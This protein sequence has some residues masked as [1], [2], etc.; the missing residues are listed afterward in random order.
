MSIPTTAEQEDFADPVQLPEQ[1][2]MRRLMTRGL[3]ASEAR[4]ALLVGD[5]LT[6]REIGVRCGHRENTVKVYLY[7]T[8]GKLSL[9]NRAE[10]A[11]FVAGLVVSAGG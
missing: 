3:T 4:I 7:R 2:L 1:L 10:L 9:A 6:N 8:Y 11:V 5:G